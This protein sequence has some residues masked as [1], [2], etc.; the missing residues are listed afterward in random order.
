MR[1]LPGGQCGRP[2]GTQAPGVE[3]QHAG[4]ALAARLAA[5][6]D[7]E[8]GGVAGAGAPHDK[9]TAAAQR[10]PA[11]PARDARLA[12]VRWMLEELRVSLFAQ[13]LGTPQPVSPQRI[14]AALAG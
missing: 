7:R 10:G 1:G 13:T 2:R 6:S 9:R 8:Q 3:P 14:R 12:E 5:Q 4:E 11:D